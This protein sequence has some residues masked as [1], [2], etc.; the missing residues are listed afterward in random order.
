NRIMNIP[1]VQIGSHSTIGN[2]NE[3]VSSPEFISSE[4]I[5]LRGNRPQ[6]IIGEHSGISY[7]NYFDVQD[8][9]IIG[10][11]TTIAGIGSVF[12]TH[13]LDVNESTQTTREIVI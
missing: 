3:F 10:S 1:Y 6:L 8:Q 12:F 9:L 11:F 2:D 4:G 5:S 7:Q 13:F